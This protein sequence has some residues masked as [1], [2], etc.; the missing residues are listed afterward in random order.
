MK[1]PFEPV[2]PAKTSL[3]IAPKRP[4]SL[5]KSGGIPWGQI[6]SGALI[7]VLFGSAAGLALAL[8]QAQKSAQNTTQVVRSEIAASNPVTNSGTPDSTI[9][10]AAKAESQAVAHVSAKAQLRLLRGDLQANPRPRRSTS[11]ARVAAKASR[12]SLKRSVTAGKY[13]VETPLQS[14]ASAAPEERAPPEAVQTATDQTHASSFYVEG[15]LRV[16]DYDESAGTIETSDG[17][18]FLVGSNLS[19]STSETWLNSPGS[20]HYRCGQDGSC[21]LNRAGMVLTNVRQI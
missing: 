7:G 20:L 18:T 15:S 4:P 12:A 5:T 21:V 14:L 13:A 19:T 8:T 2:E 3:L 17:R 16:L 6:T 11:S 9:R 10:V 1:T